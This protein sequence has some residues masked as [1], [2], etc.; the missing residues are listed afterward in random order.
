MSHYF[1]VAIVFHDRF[2]YHSVEARV[3]HFQAEHLL[4]QSSD[5]FAKCLKVK[6]ISCDL[7]RPNVA[8]S[9]L[10]GFRHL[11]QNYGRMGGYN[12]YTIPI[13]QEI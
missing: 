1:T 7:S 11:L 2:R 4:C 10:A 12:R 8:A 5:V 3:C 9:I 13:N 6:S